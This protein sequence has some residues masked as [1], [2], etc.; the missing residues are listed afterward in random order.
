MFNRNRGQLN[1]DALNDAAQLAINRAERKEDTIN[2]RTDEDGKRICVIEGRLFADTGRNDIFRVVP[3]G[4]DD[5]RDLMSHPVPKYL[6]RDSKAY[7]V[8]DAKDFMDKAIE[9]D[10]RF[11]ATKEGGMVSPFAETDRNIAII[12]QNGMPVTAKPGDYVAALSDGS[13]GIV[14]K[15]DFDSSY[16]TLDEQSKSDEIDLMDGENA[17]L[18]TIYECDVPMEL[19]GRMRHF[20][21]LEAAFQAHKDPS[22][23]SKFVGITGREAA[24]LGKTV[25]VRADW[26]RVKDDIMQDCIASKFENNPELAEKLKQTDGPIIANNLAGDHYW[27]ICDGIGE[28]KFGEMLMSQRESLQAEDSVEAQSSMSL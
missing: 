2:V 26:D 6:V 13:Y 15:E 23:A 1:M 8:V 19:G 22:C 28:N 20:S 12:S 11:F 3:R 10:S 27:G 25:D 9:N 21:S 7:E 4:M 17:Y 24:A 14:T 5:A 16:K 18:S